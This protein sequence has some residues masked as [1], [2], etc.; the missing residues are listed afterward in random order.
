MLNKGSGQ[1]N[2]DFAFPA[3]FHNPAELQITHI[4]Q[5]Y[6]SPGQ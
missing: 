4:L 2:E 6:A 5:S 1:S 3:D